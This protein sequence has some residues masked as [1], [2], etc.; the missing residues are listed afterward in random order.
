MSAGGNPYFKGTTVELNRAKYR[1]KAGSNM[2]LVV[3]FS[4]HSLNC[5]NWNKF[6]G[7]EEKL[8]EEFT[9]S[10]HNPDES[11]VAAS[12]KMGGQIQALVS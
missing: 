11:L 12:P 4:H 2:Y 7:H 5:L 8:G 10:G 1:S 9:N 3:V 6:L